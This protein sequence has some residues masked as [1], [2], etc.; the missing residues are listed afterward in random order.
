MEMI[1]LPTERIDDLLTHELKII[2]SN[3]VFSFSMD[4][5]LLARFVSLPVRR[6]KIMDL[7]TGNGVIP[8][9]MSTRTNATI[10]GLEIQER[11][12]D[13][14]TR[15][16][17]LNKLS[18]RIEVFLEDLKEAPQRFGHGQYDVVTCNPP[19]MS[20]GTGDQN[21]NE[22]VA[23]A[24]HEIYCTL[25]DVIRVSAYLTRSGGKVAMVHR[26]SRF[27]DLVN[28]MRKYRIEPKRVRFVHPKAGAEANM[29]LVEGIR[30][31][32]PDL[33]VLPPLIVYD[34]AGTYCPELLDIYYGDKLEL[35]GKEE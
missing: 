33:K 28:Y 14:A 32:K 18:N 35:E 4:A 21:L 22:H 25:E 12:H 11:L 31:G 34:E 15:N 19:Y 3:E 27:T 29:V 13:M 1:L 9:L 17:I 30:D 6:G 7:C 20:G 2:Q 10:E 23:I 16:V 5:V 26:P 24:R 8:L